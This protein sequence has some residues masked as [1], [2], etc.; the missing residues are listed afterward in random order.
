MKGTTMTRNS[1]ADMLLFSMVGS[2]LTVFCCVVTIR[3]EFEPGI[4]LS[5]ATTYIILV[6]IVTGLIISPLMHWCFHNRNLKV[7]IPRVYA[8]SILITL[9][10]NFLRIPGNVLTMFATF[11]LFLLITKAFFFLSPWEAIEDSHDP[12]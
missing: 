7:W 12:S 6:A 10:V 4:V 1:F 2:F 8:A 3:G 9:G 11:T 5:F